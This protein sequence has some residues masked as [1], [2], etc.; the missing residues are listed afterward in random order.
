MKIAHIQNHSPYTPKK[1]IEIFSPDELVDT[2][3]DT[4]M[5]VANTHQPGAGRIY[6]IN[7]E[8]SGHIRM[9]EFGCSNNSKSSL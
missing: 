5:T 9:G 3:F 6:V 7:V 1:R 2:I 4:V 8:K